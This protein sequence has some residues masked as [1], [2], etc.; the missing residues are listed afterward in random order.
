MAETGKWSLRVASLS[1]GNRAKL[2]IR[3]QPSWVF[4]SFSSFME[5]NPFAPV[6]NNPFI[7]VFA[8]EP[9]SK[10]SSSGDLSS[11]ESPY[12]S[13]TLHHLRKWSKDHP[14]DNIIGTPSR[15]V[16]T[17]KQLATDALWC[18]YNSVMSKV[19]PKNF[20]STI[21]EDCWFQ[22]MQDEIHE[23]DKLQ[24]WELVPQPDCVMIIA[25][26]WIYKVKLDEY[27]DV[28]KNKARFSDTD[29]RQEG[30]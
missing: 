11:V 6:D 13:Q 10:A 2:A 23:F 30:P 19:E 25:L 9:S 26:K 3:N 18:L 4:N 24:V 21:T 5:D 29:F 14:L 20:K 22:A 17:R 28:L 7:N 12:V 1:F 27:G 16:S 8:P 15:P